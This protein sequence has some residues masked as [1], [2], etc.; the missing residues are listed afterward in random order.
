[1][2]TGLP[3]S[4][5]RFTSSYSFLCGVLKQNGNTVSVEMCL[6]SADP[7]AL[8]AMIAEMSAIVES[9]GFATEVTADFPAW[10][11]V[12]ESPLREATTALYKQKYGKD[13]KVEAVHGGLECGVI[14]NNMPGIDIV[15]L[16]CNAEGAHT[17]EEC[18]YLDSFDRFYH[19]ILDLLAILK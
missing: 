8:E 13:M 15:A 12:S 2:R 1:M 16:G 19:Y 5:C 3:S 9:N 18:L 10:N 11:L 6:R 14:Y 7:D 4:L 17:P